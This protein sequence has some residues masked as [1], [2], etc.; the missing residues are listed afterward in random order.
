MGPVTQFAGQDGRAEGRGAPPAALPCRNS[1]NCTN[2]TPPDYLDPTPFDRKRAFALR[3]NVEG[4]MAYWGREHTLFFTLTDGHGLHPR[5]FAQRW[6]SWKTHEG[7]WLAGFLKVLEPQ[8]NGRPHYHNLAAVTFDTQPDRFDWEAF[9]AAADAHDRRD[10]AAFRA[11]RAAY[12]KS[13]APE[14]RELWARTRAEMPA[15]GLGRCEILP[16]RKAGAISEY[17][18]K[19]LEKGANFRPVEWKGVRRT[20]LDRT[21][22]QDWRRAS[23]GFSWV[24]PGA[25]AWR[26][27]CRELALAL[28]LP[29]S[30]DV[31][32]LAK[33]LGPRWAYRL[34]GAI[35]T[36]SDTEWSETLQALRFTSDARRFE[37]EYC[38]GPNAAW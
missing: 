35:C 36:A 29:D 10:W 34:R 19:Y 16:I 26:T 4:F 15:Y 22:S 20:E 31:S 24:S 6:H 21:T 1:N 30:G 14:L 28:G 37:V 23:T 13:A 18:G 25:T 11:A 27:R 3:R 9:D 7:D 5:E 17:V 33:K 32:T 2:P 12:V 38:N 8:R